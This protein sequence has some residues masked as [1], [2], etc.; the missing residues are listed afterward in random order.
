MKGMSYSLNIICNATS[1]SAL[2]HNWERVV[3]ELCER[4]N[5]SLVSVGHRKS[6]FNYHQKNLHIQA[7]EHSSSLVNILEMERGS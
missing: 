5:I 7:Y 4:F 6:L 3:H 1:T 2:D